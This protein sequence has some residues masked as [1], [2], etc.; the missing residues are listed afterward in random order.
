[1]LQNLKYDDEE[2]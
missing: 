1:K 2:I